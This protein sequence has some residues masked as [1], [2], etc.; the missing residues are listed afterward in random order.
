MTRSSEDDRPIIAE[1]RDVHRHYLMGTNVVK[2]LNGVSMQVRKGD[3]LAI[4]GRSGSGKSTMLNLLGCLDR[5][6]DG[7]Y[8]VGGRDV[9]KLDDDALSDVRGREIGFIFQSF[10]LIPQLTVLENLE[11][12]LFYQNRIGPESRAKAEKLATR[13]GLGGRLDHRPLELSGGQQQRVAIA[14]ALMNDPLFLLADE[15]TGNLDSNTELE[16]LSLLDELRSEGVTIVI[17]THNQ[18]VADRAD[19]TLWL[20]DGRVE[21]LVD[22]RTGTAVGG[23]A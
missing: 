19:H 22:N 4:M 18:K 10:N 14:R 8:L 23:P 15:A 5:P 12:P 20:K 16:I 21:K 11:V 9:S 2:A 17:V 7:A 6:T 1:F 3:Y 13:V